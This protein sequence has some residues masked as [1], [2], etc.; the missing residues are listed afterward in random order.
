M[1][2]ISIRSRFFLLQNICPNPN[3]SVQNLSRLTLK[4]NNLQDVG[5]K[6]PPPLVLHLWWHTRNLTNLNSGTK[7]VKMRNFKAKCVTSLFSNEPNS[8]YESYCYIYIGLISWFSR[9]GHESNCVLNCPIT[10]SHF[11]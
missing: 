7:K 1:T 10:V 3:N 9:S 2:L 11:F 8:F 6:H 5:G 4:T